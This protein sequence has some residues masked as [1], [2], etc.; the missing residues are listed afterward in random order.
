METF[1]FVVIGYG[2][3][4][5]MACAQLG[6][7]GYSIAAFER[8]PQ[9]YGLTRAGHIDDEI[10]RTLQ[11][12]GAADEFLEDAFAWQDYDMRTKAFGGEVLLHLDWSVIGP[13]GWRA[14]WTF[15]QNNLENA[16]H[17]KVMDT[18][19]VTVT[20]A[21]EAVALAQDAEGVTVTVRSVG[22]TETRRIRAKYL[23][24]ADGANS[25]VRNA[26]EIEEW[27][28]RED[29]DQLV[30]D[31]LQKRPLKFDFDNGQFADPSRPGC[32][33]QLGKRNRR[34]EFTLLPH[35]KPE[36]FTEQRV[37]ELL[38]PWVGKDDVEILRMPVY[39]FREKIAHHWQRDRV[40][41]VGDAAHRLWPFAG[42]GMC[43]G[44]RDV[45][46]LVWRL[47]L[48][49]KGLAPSALLDSY[50]DDRKPNFTAW[51]N[52]SREIGIPCIVTDPAIAEARNAGF[53]AVQK[54]PSLMPPMIV[55]PGPK[56]FARVDDETA[57]AI[58]QQGRVR[59]KGAEGLFDDVV[60]RGWV[61]ISDAP[62]QLDASQRTFLDRIGVTQ[63]HV[64]PAGS[65]APVV[66][67]DG[68]YQRWLNDLGQHTVLVRP[69]FHVWGS[70]RDQ[71]DSVALVREFEAA[72][73]TGRSPVSAVAAAAAAA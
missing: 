39:R 54:D 66:D 62:L 21:T 56:A 46:T 48:V 65:G 3:V 6:R 57:G 40:F 50:T 49:M 38:K 10:V 19:K 22:G 63:A 8:H 47:D 60:G 13:H 55:P 68:T 42:E 53:F 20:L 27:S 31:T 67:L 17:R 26:L 5:Q 72:I 14:H 12:I 69:D 51:M 29:V 7:A 2:P 59:H 34:W 24:G 25:F 28:G 64:G 44:I 70:A 1:D 23:L 32:L 45:S 18:G 58:G 73:K 43:N 9:M 36:D 41:L 11:G 61:L 52:L 37:W 15:N 33:F 16:I 4:G 71:S 35:E 30:I